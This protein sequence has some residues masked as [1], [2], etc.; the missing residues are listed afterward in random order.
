MTT[1]DCG[2]L[3]NLAEVST[4]ND[5]SDEDEGLITVLCPELGIDK[6]TETPEVNAGDEVD[7]TIALANT[8]TGPANDVIITDDLPE[9]ITWSETS[10]DC[11]I[12]DGT[13]TCG[14]MTIAA[15]ASFSVTLTGTTDAGECPSIENSANFTSSN[16]GRGSTESEPTEIIVNCP[17]LAVEKEGSGV[18][19]A[20]DDVRFT[21]TVTNNGEGDAKDVELVDN[22]PALGS[23]TWAVTDVVGI[24]ADDCEISG[25]VLT[26]TLG[27][28][29][30][31]ASFSVT[32][33][34]TSDP[35]DCPSLANDASVSASN[36][37][38]DEATQADNEDS[39]TITVNCP[40][41]SI[42]K[43]ATTPVVN[44]GDE[45][46]FRIT[47][48]AGG[49]GTNEDVTLTDQL[50][51]SALDWS[52]EVS[53]DGTNED[54]SIDAGAFLTCEF[55]H[56]EPSSEIIVDLTYRTDAD[57]C[58]SIANQA[59]VSA[60]DDVDRT[61]NVSDEVT[62]TVNCP[63]VTV[64]K[65]PVETPISA[66]EQ[67]QFTIEVTNDG[68]GTAYGVEV[69]DAAPLGTVW[70]VLDDGGFDC[71]SEV[72]EDQQT[73]TCTLDELAAEA[74]ATILIGYETTQEDCGDLDN[75]VT[76]SAD[77]EPAGNTEDNSDEASI[78]VECPGLNMDKTADANP[79][80]AGE[81]ASF[82][83]HVW[84]RGDGEAF[85][86]E[87]HDDL[88]AGLSW[89][90]EIVSGDATDADCMVASSIV[91]GG[92]QQM[93]ID[94]D[95]GTLGVTEMADGIVIRLFAETTRDDCGTLVNEAWADASND[96]RRDDDATIV[97]KCP[98]IGILK[99]NDAVGSV[100]PGTEVTY[101]LT[102][103]ISDGP[104]DDVQVIDSMPDG[105]ESP[106][107]I[108]DGGV[109]DATAGSI[110]W[111]LGDLADGEY[112]LT[113]QAVVSDDVEQGDELVNVASA[114]S[115][116]SQ[117][118]DLETLGPECEDDS[119]V[120]VRV[121]SLVIDKVADT[122]L[123][124]ITGPNDALV[125]TP[126]V[127]T[128]TLSYTLANGPVTNAVIT[129]EIPVGFEFLDAADGGTL[130][131]GVVSWSFPTLTESGSVTFRTTVD[132]ETI[133]RVAPTVNVAVIESDETPADE[134]EDGVAVAVEPPPL[135]GNPTPTPKP[136]LPDTAAGVGMNGEP[137]TV[138]IELLAALFLGSLGSLALATVKARNRRR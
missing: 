21:M 42:E 104:A 65:E 95:F 24:G 87:L 133:S 55:G 115:P 125:A 113:Y 27:Q 25:E 17:D 66:G 86:V 49:S 92:V 35:Q 124:T 36:E 67:G 32:V 88:P 41:T 16:A 82:T 98:E 52:V 75:A 56:L 135:A 70:T 30:S 28:L 96:D 103:S 80:D 128:W 9:G 48:T 61:D 131:D 130:V 69:V 107:E 84:N 46:S 97:V 138:P 136:V 29:A 68:P 51:G 109:F 112:A 34:A 116:N 132:P 5:G 114:T 101:T 19:V 50:T 74:S 14:P 7:Y 58:P 63:D 38:S 1:D 106:T 137:I 39:H 126:S 8:G 43:D 94:C 79:I 15:S 127:V 73:I 85:D 10:E 72:A 20:G 26:C 53:G 4:S 91:D 102:L 129:D 22:L 122:E 12:A 90:F 3:N 76:V 40:D 60:T 64:D 117:C 93:S 18:V 37:A 83:I 78:V 59:M 47:V 45:A 105:L 23:G 120:I 111:N 99:A 89:D 2:P 62:I 33:S 71:A 44:A 13:L 134:G 118:P 110:T 77:N 123:I 11:E 81:E 119:T 54:C 100:L 57:D 31:G 121:P 6:T 108:S